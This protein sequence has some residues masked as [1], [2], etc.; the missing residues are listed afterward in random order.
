MPAG[1]KEVMK[2]SGRVAGGR[3]AGGRPARE[4]RVQRGKVGAGQNKR[5]WDGGW[6]YGRGQ[7]VLHMIRRLAQQAYLTRIAQAMLGLMIDQA[8]LPEE[9][10]APQ[11]KGQ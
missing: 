2:A 8:Q 4:K 11:E 10:H 5:R 6:K 9:K 1:G 3:T 7:T